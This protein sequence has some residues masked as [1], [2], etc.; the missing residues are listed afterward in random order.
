D[1]IRRRDRPRRSR[2]PAADANAGNRDPGKLPPCGRMDDGRARRSSR[3][4]RVVARIRGPG[5]RRA[6]GAAGRADPDAR[7][8]AC[9]LR[10]GVGGGTARPL[11]PV[12]ECRSDRRGFARA[13]FSR[14]IDRSW[15]ARNREPDPL[16]CWSRL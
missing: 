6:D 13:A 4:W 12:A 16:R 2:H 9:P 11:Q 14:T 15:R 8:R 10:P 1:S 7:G 3:P 5:A